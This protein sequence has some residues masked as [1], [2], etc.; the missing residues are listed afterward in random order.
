M[1]EDVQ[2]AKQMLAALC[3][4]QGIDPEKAGRLPDDAVPVRM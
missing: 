4:A 2:R 1:W 3:E